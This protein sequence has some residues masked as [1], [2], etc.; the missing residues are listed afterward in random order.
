MLDPFHTYES[1]D[2]C[3]EG[4]L[5]LLEP[6]GVMLSMTSS[7]AWTRPSVVLTY[8]GWCGVT[9]AAMRD[10]CSAR[11]V[12]WFTIDVDFGIGV[13]DPASGSGSDPTSL[14]GTLNAC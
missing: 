11:G 2:E 12:E 14:R 10:V 7:P 6:G 3:I 1:S 8:E 4:C 9:F 13:A 5:D